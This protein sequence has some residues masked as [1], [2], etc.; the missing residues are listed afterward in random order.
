MLM[1]IVIGVT[2]ALT[3]S[4]FILFACFSLSRLWLIEQSSLKVYLTDAIDKNVRQQGTKK[5][6]AQ[7]QFIITLNLP[8]TWKMWL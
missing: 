5:Q 1:L 7:I 2:D 3:C 4:S 8:F 6:L